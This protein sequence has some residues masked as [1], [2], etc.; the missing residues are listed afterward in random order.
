ML[1]IIDNVYKTLDSSLNIK[2]DYIYDGILASPEIQGYRN[3]MEF[4]FGDEYKGGP[5][6][7]GLHKKEVSMTL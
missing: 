3:K 6:T 2:K 7:L 4:S 1:E 5:L